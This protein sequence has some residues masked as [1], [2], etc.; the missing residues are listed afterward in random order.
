M[1]WPIDAS[2]AKYIWGNLPCGDRSLGNCPRNIIRNAQVYF[3]ASPT[4]VV[5]LAVT[6][7]Q[8]IADVTAPVTLETSGAMLPSAPFARGD[9]FESAS[10][11]VSDSTGAGGGHWSS[12]Q[13]LTQIK[14]TTSTWDAQRWDGA[15]ELTYGADR[16]QCTFSIERER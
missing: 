9:V 16:L 10:L 7:P 8:D 15:L 6:S 5:G 2:F 12:T 13:P 11:A 1:R 4:R 3:T 14:F